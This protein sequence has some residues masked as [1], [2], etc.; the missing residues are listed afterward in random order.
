VSAYDENKLEL[1]E[2]AKT[3]VYCSKQTIWADL[4]DPSCP[5]LKP[6]LADNHRP[7]RFA[8]VILYDRFHAEDW[9]KKYLA[10]KGD[11]H[12]RKKLARE[13]WLKGVEEP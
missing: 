13:E 5:Q 8:G 12:T 1:W 7:L 11:E 3:L 4:R 10:W 6:I 2:I 9:A